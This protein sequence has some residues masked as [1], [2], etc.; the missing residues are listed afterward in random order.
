M[1]CRAWLLLGLASLVGVGLGP[2]GA[3]EDLEHNRRLL[4]EHRANPDTYKRLRRDLRS[5]YALPAEQ[6]ERLRRLDRE[7][8]GAKA[9]ERERLEAVLD[10]YATWFERLPEAD[11]QRVR[12]AEAPEARLAVIREILDRQWIEGLPAK[13]QLREQLLKLPPAQRTSIVAAERQSARARRA[14]LQGARMPPFYPTRLRDLPV[15]VQEF[16]RGSLRPMLTESEAK[17]LDNAENKEWPQLLRVILNQSDRYWRPPALP[18]VHG[19]KGVTGWEGLPPAYRKAFAPGP[20]KKG[21]DQLAKLVENLKQSE[22]QWPAFALR[23]TKLAGLIAKRKNVSLP[24]LGACRPNDFAPPTRKFIL[25]QFKPPLLTEAELKELKKREGRW[26]EYPQY[27][28]Q[29]AREKR[30]T[31]PGMSLPG[32]PGLWVNVRA[33]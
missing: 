3:P 27:L 10:R 13:S 33:P 29:L 17:R 4:N 25:E 8:R 5:F 20:K 23:A 16:V 22:G 15:P 2:G 31:I 30:L 1:S 7:L 24:P 28:H 32:P 19:Q 6:Q 21:A 9:P 12:A 26:P 14:R 18:P 11:R